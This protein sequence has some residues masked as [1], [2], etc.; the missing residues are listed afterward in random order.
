MGGLFG[1]GSPAP[2]PAPV[3]V[4]I[5]PEPTV[6]PIAD[7]TAA[8]KAKKRSLLKQQ[9]RSGRASTILSTENKLG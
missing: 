6:M 7:D 5:I 1:G 2:I 9:S 3:Q 8:R 4:P